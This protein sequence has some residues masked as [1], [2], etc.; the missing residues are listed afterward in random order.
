MTMKLCLTAALCGALAACATPPSRIKADAS[1]AGA[2]C[3]RADRVRLADLSRE[4]G[5]AATNDAVGVFLIG[6]PLGSM[7]GPDHEKEIAR[8][9]GACG[10]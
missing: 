8:L 3:S 1:A 4:Q 9:K 7:T 10:G 6:L 5:R 2:P